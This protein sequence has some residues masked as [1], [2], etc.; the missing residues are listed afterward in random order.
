M[1]CMWIYFF[2]IKVG[3][4]EINLL[5]LRPVKMQK[6]KKSHHALR[7]LRATPA[8]VK[9]RG[10]ML[11]FNSSRDLC[12]SLYFSMGPT[13]KRPT[14]HPIRARLAMRL[15]AAA[16]TLPRTPRPRLPPPPVTLPIH[17]ISAATL[18]GHDG[19][20]VFALGLRG[21]ARDVSAASAHSPWNRPPLAS[22]RGGPW[23]RRAPLRGGS[24]GGIALKVLEAVPRELGFL[25]CPLHL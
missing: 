23:R 10:L 5:F 25:A 12:M 7:L 24:L 20:A 19:E 18:P 9:K 22:L 2:L 13:W 14:L 15:R 17:A 8:R 4:K 21:Q 1:K 6:S 16:A 3:A 11:A